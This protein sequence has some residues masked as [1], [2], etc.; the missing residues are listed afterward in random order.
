MKLN[1]AL[2]RAKFS[3]VLFGNMETLEVMLAKSFD[4]Y[5]L[6]LVLGSQSDVG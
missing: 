2:T 6:R 3:L 5:L 4:T 1:V